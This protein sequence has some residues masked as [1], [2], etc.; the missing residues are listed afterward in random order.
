MTT[1]QSVSLIHYFQHQIDEARTNPAAII[2][3]LQERAFIDD[4]QFA[5]SQLKNIRFKT[6]EGM[7]AVE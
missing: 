1:L 3:H 2:K 7:A 6:E 5:H 4:D